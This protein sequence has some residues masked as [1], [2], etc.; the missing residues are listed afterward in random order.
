MSATLTIARYVVQE[1]VRR[2]VFVVVLLL[3]AV[4]LG[5]YALPDLSD[6]GYYTLPRGSVTREMR[7]WALC[8]RRICAPPV[9]VS[10]VSLPPE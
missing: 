9:C 7:P 4:F 3:T 6:Q 5:L 1:A 2:K 10:D 8:S